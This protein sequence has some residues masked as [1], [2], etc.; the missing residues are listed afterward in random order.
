MDK[1][2]VTVN[3]NQRYRAVRRRSELLCAPLCVEDYVPQ[4]VVDVSPPKWHLGHTTWFFEAFIL[5]PYRPGY[6]VFHPVYSFIFNSY[7][8]AM[9]RRVARAERGYLS[10]PTVAEVSAYRAAIDAAMLALLDAGVAPGVADLIE[11][12]LQ[13]EQ[14]HQ[15]LLVTDIK[16]ILALNPLVPAY[17]PQHCGALELAAEHEVETSTEAWVWIDAGLYAVGHAG[18]GFAFDNETPRHSVQVPAVELRT[19]LVSNGEF[20]DFMRDGGYER[21]EFWHAEGWDWMRSLALRAPLYWRPDPEHAER[22]RHYTLGG[23]VPLDPNAPLTHVSYYEAAAFCEWAGWRLPT[24]FEWEALAG[25][26][27]WGARWEWTESAY[28]P[29]PGFRKLAGAVGEYNGKFMVNQKVLRGASFA[30]APHHARRSYRNF[31]HPPLRWQYTGIR[32]ARDRD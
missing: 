9:G 5:Q 16:Y 6:R 20:L 15:E 28:A 18:E 26:F 19:R 12:G 31:F 3:L 21:F 10:R 11:L 30:T 32:P 8:E 29:Y 2:A 23:E 27:A 17:D 24:E 4:P 14:Q 13:H 25:D 1:S 22:Y 7:Y